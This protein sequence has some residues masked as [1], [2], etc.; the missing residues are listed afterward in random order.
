M[1]K[2]Q[3]DDVTIKNKWDYQRGKLLLDMNGIDGKVLT[4][5]QRLYLEKEITLFLWKS[6]KEQFP[7]LEEFLSER[8]G[9]FNTVDERHYNT[10]IICIHGSF[11]LQLINENSRS[12]WCWESIDLEP[13]RF[14]FNEEGYF[15]SLVIKGINDALR[16]G[17]KRNGYN[18]LIKALGINEWELFI[19]TD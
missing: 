5:E 1:D 13:Y 2:I 7:Q 4:N 3:L 17:Y 14:Y 19:K 10:S 12:G 9:N 18:R 6:V 8:K 11:Y 16:R 15:K